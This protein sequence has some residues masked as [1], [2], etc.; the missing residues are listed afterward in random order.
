[1]I[2]H[3]YPLQHT[4]QWTLHYPPCTLQG[5]YVYIHNV[6]TEGLLFLFTGEPVGD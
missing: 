6:D 5:I 4:T 1:M 2:L 3:V